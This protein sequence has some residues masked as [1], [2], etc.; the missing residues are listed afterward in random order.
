M[1]VRV[2]KQPYRLCT[3]DGG[4]IVTDIGKLDKGYLKFLG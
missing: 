1:G 4:Q 3:V 2:Y